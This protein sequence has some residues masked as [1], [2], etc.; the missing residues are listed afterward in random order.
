MSAYQDLLNAVAHV[1]G[2]T[3]PS[4][5]QT[6]APAVLQPYWYS[7]RDS[8]DGTGVAGLVGCS[9]LPPE[10]IQAT[11]VGMVLPGPWHPLEATPIGGR[12]F[13][14]DQIHV[15]V[16]VGHDDLTTQMARLVPVRDLV[17]PAFDGHMQLF[18]TPG[19][20]TAWC[21]DGD[22]MEVSWGGNVYVAL[23]FIVHVQRVLTT[24]YTG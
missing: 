18:N 19:V 7:G 20:T 13:V 21:A 23:V 9:S 1:V 4:A 22:F 3:Q 24:T 15:R 16:L 2:G 12:K 5:G 17:P 10:I 8:A 11:P 14:E 6:T